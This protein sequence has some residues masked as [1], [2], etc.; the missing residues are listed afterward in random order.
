MVSPLAGDIALCSCERHSYSASLHKWVLVNVLLG[1]N[2]AMNSHPIRGRGGSR[3][4][5]SP[6]MLLKPG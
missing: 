1:S 6:F 3:N 4:T 5:P 2:P